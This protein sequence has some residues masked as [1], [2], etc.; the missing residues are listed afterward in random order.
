MQRAARERLQ[1]KVSSCSLRVR[2]PFR[3]LRIRHSSFEEMAGS[4]SAQGKTKASR[5]VPSTHCTGEAGAMVP[6]T[7]TWPFVVTSCKKSRASCSST[8]ERKLARSAFAFC[9][10]QLLRA[11]IKSVFSSTTKKE[12][13]RGR[14]SDVLEEVDVLVDVDVDVLVLLE[15]VEKGRSQMKP[16]RAVH[17]RV[18]QKPYSILLALTEKRMQPLSLGSFASQGRTKFSA[19][20]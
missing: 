3:V 11:E 6:P 18:C 15:V 7:H 19:A 13:W 14:V 9:A 5:G 16:R 17:F 8:S 4:S 12:T 2:R 10:M 20:S 1:L